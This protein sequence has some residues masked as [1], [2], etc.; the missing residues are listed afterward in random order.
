MV[1]LEGVVGYVAGLVRARAA[2]AGV[3]IDVRWEPGLA[4]EIDEYQIHRAL[5]NLVTNALDA[6]PSGGMIVVGAKHIADDQVE[7]FVENSGPAIPTQDV[8]RIFEPFFTS[9]DRGTGL[10][11]PIALSIARGHGGDL[12]LSENVEGRVRFAMNIPPLDRGSHV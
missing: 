6:T 9:R 10:G 3:R 2:D 8:G 4:A 7:F 1:E 5:L 11:L 12:R